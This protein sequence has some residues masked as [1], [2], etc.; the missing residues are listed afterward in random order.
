[1]T[2]LGEFKKLKLKEPCFKGEEIKSIEKKSLKD[3]KLYDY[4]EKGDIL[5]ESSSNELLLSFEKGGEYY[6]YKNYL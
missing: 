1:M 2:S 6:D 4:L 3:Y 5:G